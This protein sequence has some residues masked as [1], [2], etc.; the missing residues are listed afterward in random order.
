MIIRQ[1]IGLFLSFLEFMIFLECIFSWFLPL[2][3]SRA[4]ELIAKFN[5]PFLSP[6]RK[7]LYKYSS[8]GMMMDLSPLI[9][10]LII[11]FIKRFFYL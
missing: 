5:S 7:L 8:A 1:I 4:Y 2:R 9:L 3:E 10:F 6:V 11:G